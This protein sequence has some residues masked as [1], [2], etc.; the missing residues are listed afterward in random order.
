MLATQTVEPFSVSINH[1]VKSPIRHALHLLRVVA[2]DGIL[3][4]L[5]HVLSIEVRPFCS[6]FHTLTILH[7]VVATA[8][9]PNTQASLLLGLPLRVFVV[10]FVPA[11]VGACSH[12]HLS[13][14][15]PSL[16]SGL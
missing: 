15:S 14:H 6:S 11:Y 4:Q 12:F 10:L 7:H 8:D 2:L 5:R 16:S 3:F 1:I 9:F 13:C